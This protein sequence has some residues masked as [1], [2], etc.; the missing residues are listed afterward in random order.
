MA[1]TPENIGGP[2]RTRTC[3]QTVMSGGKPHVSYKNQAISTTR[4]QN[5]SSSKRSYL[6]RRQCGDPPTPILF[7]LNQ[8]ERVP[9]VATPLR[10]G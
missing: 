8:G 2:G 6:G 1:Q 7:F 9:V 4:N 10:T 3:N 5:R